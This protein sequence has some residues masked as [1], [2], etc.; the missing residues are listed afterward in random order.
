[1]SQG[2]SLEVLADDEDDEDRLRE[3]TEVEKELNLLKT[4]TTN[5]PFAITKDEVDSKLLYGG[6]NQKLI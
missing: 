4:T 2:S 1:M 5:N 3:I 6:D